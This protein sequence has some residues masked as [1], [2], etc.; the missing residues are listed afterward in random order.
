[1]RPLRYDAKPV[2]RGELALARA[3]NTSRS[4][5]RRR[6][7]AAQRAQRAQREAD[8]HA[9]AEEPEA[10]DSQQAEPEQRP[11]LFQP[12]RFREDLRL[13]PRILVSR[14]LM[15]VPPLIM[16]VGFVLTLIGDQLADDAAGMADLYVQLLF[17]PPALLTYFLAGFIVE[18]ASYLIGFLLG[19]LSAVLWSILIF[20]W[21]L[22]AVG[23]VVPDEARVP[24]ALQYAFF[25]LVWGPLGAAFAAWYRDFLRRMQA[26]GRARRAEQEAKERERRRQQRHEDRRSLKRPTR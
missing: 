22:A 19:L 13:L 12:P 14:R 6:A 26:R 4:E 2:R 24:F 11:S 15:I 18:R 1:M 21:G 20:G 5:S 17:L 3:K 16:L 10:A 9:T 25:S 8:A 23:F 7:R